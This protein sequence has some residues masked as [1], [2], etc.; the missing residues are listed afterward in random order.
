[1][2]F[3]VAGFGS[4][5]K[6]TADIES[7]SFSRGAVHIVLNRAARI[8]SVD[9]I[10]EQ[11]NRRG[12]AVFPHD[13]RNDHITVNCEWNEKTEY[14]IS[15]HTDERNIL[16]NTVSPVYGKE[17]YYA[18][19]F[20]FG[21]ETKR[22][23]VPVDTEITGS[24]RVANSMDSPRDISVRIMFPAGFSPVDGKD[25]RCLMN[26]GARVECTFALRLANRY[27]SRIIPL[28]VKSPANP[29][30]EYRNIS[31]TV[32]ENGAVLHTDNIQIRVVNSEFLGKSIRVS[33]V[34]FP[35]NDK[36][37]P[38][39][40]LTKN[41]LHLSTVTRLRAILT[42]EKYR[43]TN[44]RQLPFGF[45][46]VTVKNTLGEDA[47][48][49]LK[50]CIVDAESGERVEAFTPDPHVNP[51]GEVFATVIVKREAS[52]KVVLP[53][54]VE[55]VSVREGDYRLLLSLTQMGADRPFSTCEHD[56]RVEKHP[57]VPFVATVAGA[58][59]A[60]AF[61]FVFFIRF[62]SIMSG[63]KVRWIV[64]ISLYGAVGFVLVNV[65]GTLFM[66]VFRALLGPFSFLAS[67]LFFGVVQYVLWTSL[68]MLVPRPGTMSL[69]MAVRLLLSWVLL[70]NLS[71]VS[72]LW[73]AVHALTA[74][75]ALWGA[76]ATRSGPERGVGAA[77][78]FVA[79]ALSESVATFFNMESVV[80]L[81]RLYYADWYIA[82]N[83]LVGGVFYTVIGTALGLSMG[84][85]LR[86]VVE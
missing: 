57:I 59:L 17:N 4:C 79:F 37:E 67:G 38:D 36:G 8:S 35:T 10:D 61:L 83:I 48:V 30:R 68:I 39:E 29:T 3:I 50:A 70:G 75:A 7:V 42:G 72:I 66:D 47:V 55:P 18:F 71:L 81:Y 86:M 73:M 11:G 40:R 62:R 15:L 41:T 23:A 85:R 64:L 84:K 21:M 14:H 12:R 45:F 69:V 80:F 51:L 58:V 76:G 46:Q 49:L 56:F 2:A 16:Y 13:Y 44:F 24:V 31:M 43:E 25:G 65:P 20:P 6:K 34:A 28:T 22:V 1:M 9:I 82:L 60:G 27:D 54:Y 32:S 78:L 63:F 26:A 5:A 53:V 74:E 52:T 19:Q 33:R 77:G